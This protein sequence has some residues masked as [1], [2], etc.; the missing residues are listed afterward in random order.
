MGGSV[1]VRGAEVRVAAW[2]CEEQ[3]TAWHGGGR[4]SD[5]QVVGRM[6]GLGQVVA[7]WRQGRQVAAW[8][9]RGR[10]GTVS[11][12]CATR[13]GGGRYTCV[14]RARPRVLCVAAAGSARCLASA[15]S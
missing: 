7:A 5:G 13:G 4:G 11:G 10:G 1:V 12:W 9:R 15:T 6:R 14:P 8:W 2:W 3:G